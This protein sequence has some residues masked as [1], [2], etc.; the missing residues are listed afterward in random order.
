MQRK[1]ERSELAE[2]RGGEREGWDEREIEGWDE[3]LRGGEREG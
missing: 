1:R 2:R 3:R